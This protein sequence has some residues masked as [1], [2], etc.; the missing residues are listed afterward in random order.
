M[1]M[2]AG[3][4][5][6]PWRPLHPTSLRPTCQVRRRRR[7][8]LPHPQHVGV[9]VAH[10]HPPGGQQRPAAATA[11]ASTTTRCRPPLHLR[12]TPTPTFTPRR[13]PRS[14][15]RCCPL[16][17][18]LLLLLWMRPRPEGRL[19]LLPLGS[20]ARGRH[21]LLQ[22][23]RPHRPQHAEG[24]IPCAPSHVQVLLPGEGP[25]RLHQP[26]QGTVICTIS[27][28]VLA[29]SVTVYTSRGVHYVR[30]GRACQVPSHAAPAL[31]SWLHLSGSPARRRTW[32]LTGGGGPRSYCLAD[33]QKH[34]ACRPAPTS[35]NRCPAPHLSFHRRCSPPLMRSFMMSYDEAT[36]LNTWPT[37]PAFCSR[38][39][40]RKPGGRDGRGAKVWAAA[41]AGEPL[42]QQ[43]Q[44][45]VDSGHR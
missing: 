43:Q 45:V 4:G 35:H 13:R 7:L 5:K 23:R 33:T 28:L 16:P 37:R 18:P 39:T 40:C 29:L 32:P 10:H 41:W 26:A 9:D 1:G 27:L 44:Q 15:R 20:S 17:G 19:P 24:D 3:A 14:C 34:Y 25:Q 42:P 2:R 30:R 12:P 31:W 8:L 11:T 21:A 38:G 6:P 36:L 22:L